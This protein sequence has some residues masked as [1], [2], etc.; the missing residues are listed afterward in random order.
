MTMAPQ[1]VFAT[2]IVTI[3]PVLVHSA[4]IVSRNAEGLAISTV[5]P[6]AG[7][8]SAGKP[9]EQVK[10]NVRVSH[11]LHQNDKTSYYILQRTRSTLPL[12]T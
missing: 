9:F 6:T 5:T 11:A 4:S 3:V 10:D 12:R 1:V 7:K 8:I 2:I